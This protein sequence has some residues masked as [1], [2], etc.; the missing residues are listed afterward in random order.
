M[1]TLGAN[2]YIGKHGYRRYAEYWQAG[3]EYVDHRIQ[4]A[5]KA[6]RAAIYIYLIVAVVGIA[7]HWHARKTLESQLRAGPASITRAREDRNPRTNL[8]YYFTATPLSGGA[9]QAEIT[10]QGSWENA[11]AF[12]T[13]FESHLARYEY[14]DFLT[15]SGIPQPARSN[16]ASL[17]MTLRDLTKDTSSPEAARARRAFLRLCT[18]AI[19]DPSLAVS[20]IGFDHLHRAT[21]LPANL[22]ELRE[23]KRLREN[24]L[25]QDLTGYLEEHRE[26]MLKHWN[27]PCTDLAWLNTHPGR[28]Q[29]EGDPSTSRSRIGRLDPDR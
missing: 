20:E 11:A 3:S 27:K 15:S 7:N 22:D 26:M 2:R 9:S 18:L 13:D 14:C 21:L 19:N 12:L 29:R 10:A 6:Q 25:D 4:Q 16:L 5:L 24:I 1:W 17:L 23:I 8:L 28:F